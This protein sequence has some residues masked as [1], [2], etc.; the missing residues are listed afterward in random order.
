MRRVANPSLSS[1]G[2]TVLV[3]YQQVL[4]EHEDLTGASRRD[5]LSDLRHFAAWYEANSIMRSTNET[6]LFRI[7]FSP[8]VITT[9]ALIRYR[10][11][12]QRDLHQK[13]NSVNRAL[14]SLKRYCSWAIQKQLISYDPSVPVKLVGEEEHAPRHLEDEEEQALVAAVT[15][16]GDAQRSCPHCLASAHGAASQGNLSTATGSGKAG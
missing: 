14:I 8:Q 16:E 6:A 15:N 9:P 5:Y 2:E 3:Q 12:L 7:E 11:Y 4:W 13:P 1:L 10:A